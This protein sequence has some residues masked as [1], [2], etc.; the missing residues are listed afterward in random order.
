MYSGVFDRPVRGKRRRESVTKERGLRV[1]ERRNVRDSSLSYCICASAPPS[2]P[3]CSPPPPTAGE[4]SSPLSAANALD[5]APPPPLIGVIPIPPNGLL[6]PP[7]PPPRER[8]LVGLELGAEP[9]L[10]CG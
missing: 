8:G 3:P 6:C 10:L 1:R 2:P 4:T 7:A 9:A 5:D